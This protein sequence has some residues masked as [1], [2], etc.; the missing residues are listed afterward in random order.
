MRAEPI[1]NDTPNNESD[2]NP[3]IGLLVAVPLGLRSSSSWHTYSS[4]PYC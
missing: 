1:V 2:H 3:A 4:G